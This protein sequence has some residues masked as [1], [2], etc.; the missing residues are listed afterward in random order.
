MNAITSP[1]AAQ[2]PQETQPVR[3]VLMV[4]GRA[5]FGGGPEHVFQLAKTVARTV[6]VYIAAPRDEP[7][8][9][10][11]Q[12]LVGP[13]RMLEIPHRKI[14]PGAFA[15]LVSF[16]RA[17]DIDVV[18]AH[19]RS[20]GIYARPAALLAGVPCFYTPNGSTP[21]SSVRTAVYATAEYLLSTITRGVIAVSGTEAEAL[22]PLCALRSRLNVINNGVEIPPHLDAPDTRLDNPLRIVHVT[23]FVY[24]KYSG[25]LLDIIESLRDMN[26]LAPFEFVILGDGPERADFEAALVSRGLDHCVKVLGAVS[27]PGPY[28][29]SAF[30]MV[31]TSRWE[32]LPLALLE[33]MA[34]GV[35]VIA[36]DVI[37]NKDAVA[38]RETGFLFDLAEPRVAAQRLVELAHYPVLWKQM[39][40]AARKR[41]EDEFSVQAMAD[42]TLR[43]YSRSPRRGAK[44]RS[45]AAG[46]SP[47][48]M[49]ALHSFR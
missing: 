6:P 22:R 8:W 4:T 16:I 19:G 30:C 35:P 28:L 31:S 17:N 47:A 14:A 34:R 12:S 1:L 15:R 24:Q 25:L 49:A 13:E 44:A 23:R 21:V 41:A 46:R 10:R 43:L 29:S 38:D 42:S 26:E 3:G 33:A 39:V 9:S 37:G 48:P 18:H 40:R 36:S 5:D 20:G 27:N 7:Y 45:G 2:H 32:G 11:Y